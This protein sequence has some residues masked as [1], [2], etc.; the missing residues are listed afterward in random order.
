MSSNEKILVLNLR[1]VKEASRIRRAPY[2]ARLIKRMVARHAKVDEDKV[3]LSDGLNKVLWERG[4]QDPP[5]KLKVKVTKRDDGTVLVEY[6][7]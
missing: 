5:V 2:A 6:Q 1:D 4:I 3:K 7:E